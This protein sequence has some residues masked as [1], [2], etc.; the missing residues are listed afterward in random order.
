M[1]DYWDDNLIFKSI[2]PIY[3]CPS[4]RGPTVVKLDN[5]NFHALMDYAAAVPGNVGD[6]P[7]TTMWQGGDFTVPTAAI[8]FGVIVR[9]QTQSGLVTPASIVDGLSNTLVLGEKRLETDLYSVGDWHDDCGWIDGWDPDVL[10]VSPSA[11]F[12]MGSPA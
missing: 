2:I 4:R 5:S 7:V 3:N 12:K 1:H 11:P 10:H 6:N 9:A 8:Y